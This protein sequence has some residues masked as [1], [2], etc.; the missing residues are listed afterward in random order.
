MYGGAREEPDHL[1]AAKAAKNEM[2]GLEA[3]SNTFVQNLQYPLMTMIDYKVTI[4]SSGISIRQG[5]RLIAMPV[6]PIDKSTLKYG[7]NDAGMNIH[8]DDPEL[9]A[10]MEKACTRLN[11]SQ[12]LTGLGKD[13]KVREKKKENTGGADKGDDVWTW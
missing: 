11:L 6:L 3:M 2:Q 8:A 10:L 9:N 1:A 13:K 5:F 4:S 7:S 12:H